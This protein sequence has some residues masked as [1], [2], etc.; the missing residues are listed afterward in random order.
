[1]M[2]PTDYTENSKII[3]SHRRRTD[4]REAKGRRR[5]LG[6]ALQFRTRMI[7]RKGWI[8]E[9]TLDRMDVPEKLMIIWFTPHQTSPSQNGC[10]S[11][12]LSS[13]AQIIL[14]AKWLVRPSRTS[15]NSSDDLCLLFSLFL[16][17]C[18]Q[19]YLT[20]ETFFFCF[21]LCK[22]CIGPVVYSGINL[23]KMKLFVMLFF[24]S[25]T[26]IMLKFTQ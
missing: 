12:N 2:P 21:A 18:S 16:L 24:I 5:W 8:E 9:R 11:K 4:R 22:Y 25:F 15:P 7:W 6:D 10:S 14:A 26:S 1:M 20:S 13:K 3:I 19:L 23:T 17:L